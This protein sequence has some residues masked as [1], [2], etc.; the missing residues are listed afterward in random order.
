[1]TIDKAFNST[2]Q[3]YDSWV[4]KALPCYEELFQVAVE[5]IPFPATEKLRVL[6]LGAGTGLFSWHVFKNYSQS[7]FTLID[8]ADKML[9]VSK[10]RFAGMEKQFSYITGDYSDSLPEF[11]YNL[12]ISSLSIHHLDDATKK[13]LFS[14][15]YKKLDQGGVFIN[16]DQIKGP[17]DYFQNLYWSTWLRRVRQTDASEEQ[18]QQSIMRRTEFDKDATLIDQLN[19]LQDTGFDRVDCLYQHYFVGVFYAQKTP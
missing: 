6:D 5:S 4:Q 15:V 19:W 10:E 16:V 12:I 8:V 14:N 18:I 3:Y 9:D 17:N 1:M 11:K 13:T 7:S 2:V